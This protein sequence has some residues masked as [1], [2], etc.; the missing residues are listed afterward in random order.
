MT[1]ALL[2]LVFVLVSSP[3]WA[4]EAP[5]AAGWSRVTRV[6]GGTP[7][8]A[9][10]SHDTAFFRDWSG[11]VVSFDG[12]T[13]TRL[14]AR[15]QSAYGRSIAVDAANHPTIAAADGI[16][17][18][19]GSSWIVASA[20][21]R[22]EVRGLLSLDDAHGYFVT[23]GAIGARDGDHF[24]LYAIGSWRRFEAVAGRSTSDLW[25]VGQGGTVMHWDGAHWTRERTNSDAWLLGVALGASDVWAWSSDAIF[26][27]D[28]SGWPTSAVG[29]PVGTLSAIV[30]TAHDVFAVGDTGVARQMGSTWSPEL[31]ANVLGQYASF[32]AACATDRFLAIVLSTGD[33]LVRT[34]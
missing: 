14:P 11:G 9:A 15:T 2:A 24:A 22:V 30:P 29:S 33:V 26:H 16:I 21:D 5:L 6:V 4:Q 34:L 23:D 8:A 31:A 28:A 13:G 3:A 20:P 19:D 18:F 17:T 27:R 1:R 32:G 7:T 25:A 12:T 10:C